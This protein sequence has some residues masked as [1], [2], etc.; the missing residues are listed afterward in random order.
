LFEIGTAILPYDPIEQP[1]VSLPD[2]G[3]N[4]FL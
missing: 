1:V 2:R 3:G 4:T